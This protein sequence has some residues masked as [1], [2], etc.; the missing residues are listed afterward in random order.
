MLAI[1][2]HSKEPVSINLDMIIQSTGG[3]CTAEQ[4]SSLE[5]QIVDV[6]P[7]LLAHPRIFT[8]I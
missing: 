4:I 6:V 7:F 2:V 8:S 5:K 3:S 1:L